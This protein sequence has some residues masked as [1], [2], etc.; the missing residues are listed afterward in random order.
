MC[1][2]ITPVYRDGAVPRLVALTETLGED[3][4]MSALSP[5]AL[6]LTQATWVSC[7]SKLSQISSPAGVLVGS[8]MRRAH[9]LPTA[10][11]NVL[12]QPLANCSGNVQQLDRAPLA[13][14]CDSVVCDSGG[15][16]SLLGQ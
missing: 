15:N 9:D 13:V 14:V 10:T 12:A 6:L 5:Q 3:R 8:M 11:S 2:S 4:E 7:R 1:P 16:G